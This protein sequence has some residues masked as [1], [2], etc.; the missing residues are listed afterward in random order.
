MIFCFICAAL[1]MGC[2]DKIVLSLQ[3]KECTVIEASF[4]EY[5]SKTHIVPVTED[6]YKVLWDENDRITL[7]GTKA[8]S[9][10]LSEGATRARFT[11]DRPISSP[12]HAIYHGSLTPSYKDGS[13][14]VDLPQTQTF[15]GDDMT[16]PEAAIMVGYSENSETITFSHAMSYIRLTLS[17]GTYA[18]NTAWVKIEP[19]GGENISGEFQI[20]HEN[21]IWTLHQK[22][23]GK[24]QVTLKCEDAG[25]PLGT[26][27]I[28][29][30]PAGTYASGLKVTVRDTG[31]HFQTKEATNKFVAEAGVI[32]DMNFTYQPNG[33]IIDADIESGIEVSTLTPFEQLNAGSITI[34]SHED[35]WNKSKLVMDKRSY[36]E[37]GAE[38]SV[39]L[40]TYS[41]ICRLDDGSYILTWQNAVGN[42]GNGE[43]TFYATSKDLKNW[44]YKGYLWQS[45]SV[46]NAKGN[47]DTRR[48]TNANI[49][50]LSD[51][52]LLAVA[53]FSTVNT[54]GTSETNSLYRPEQGLIIK[55]SADKGLTWYGEKEIYHGPCWE[56]HLM[57]L[58]SGEIQCFFS[59]SRPSVSASH[60][61]T[62][63]VY[64]NDKG[65][66]W[67]PELGAN[68]YRVMRKH[69]WN[70]YP[71]S[72]GKFGNPMYCY[73]YQMPVGIIL[74][75]T[76][77]FA[78]AME[79]A[80]A[81]IKKDT[82]NTSDQFSIAIAFS[83]PDGKW[84]YFEEGEVL[85]KSQRIDSV[86]VRGAAPY[87]VQFKSGE[88]LLAYGGTDSKQHFKLGNA[89]ATEFGT[90]FNGLPEKGSWGGLSQ[91]YS[92]S[93]ISCMRNSRDGAENANISIA[94]Y[95]LNHSI[96]ATGR[97]VVID[98]KNKE[99]MKTDEAIF[100][101]SE[102]QAQATLRCS[103]DSENY[104]FL[105]E[106][107]DDEISDEDRGYLMLSGSSLGT[108]SR[109]VEFNYSGLKATKKYSS[110]TW[111]NHTFTAEV[112][113]NSTQIEGGYLAEIKIP[114][115]VISPSGGKLMVNFGI[116]DSKADITDLSGNEKNISDWIDIKGL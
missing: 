48:F 78:F 110:S 109:R 29:A 54:Y 67:S 75:N 107:L 73:T 74:N 90:D 98:G 100:V 35:E 93:V 65:T 44:T 69:W 94:R 20:S 36:I 80:N 19:R 33:T 39:N 49:I 71:K 70:E 10:A 79:S 91:P 92:H 5:L 112:K 3:E 108:S 9:V 47:K 58:P 97:T 52:E 53:A 62:V 72:Q 66:T 83:K 7:N 82:I 43:D 31:T 15:K 99:W 50:Q 2:T 76:S 84:V 38:N 30:I 96:T 1:L 11:F 101:G 77:Q 115:S 34:N 24:N 104:Y 26:K 18:T 57:E 106:I 22:E 114:R 16:D 4:D 63:M 68:A 13:Y 55:K 42:N 45:K 12:Y 113:T 41:R 37:L 46:T 14:N 105:I 8:Q 86:V 87:L 59:E 56:A 40:P 6:R 88:T 111:S 102:C 32:Y 17:E 25:A 103:K 85:P 21:Q 89:T 23:G 95:N 51:G 116:Y 61:G 64:S 27:M 81:R 60:S 28:I